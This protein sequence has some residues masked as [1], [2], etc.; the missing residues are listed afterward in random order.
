[1]ILE[2]KINNWNRINSEICHGYFQSRFYLRDAT[3]NNI[4]QGSNPEWIIKLLK[5]L[6]ETY[7]QRTGRNMHT[8]LIP[9]F[10]D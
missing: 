5:A 2:D 9:H 7:E 10:Q 1:M 4:A 6:I 3:V 8:K